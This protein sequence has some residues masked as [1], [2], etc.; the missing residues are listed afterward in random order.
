MESSEIIRAEIM[1]I[2]NENGRTNG[3][4]L[5]KRAI[6]KVGNEKTVYAEISAMVESGRIEKRVYSKSHIEY[7]IINYDKLASEQLEEIYNNVDMLFITIQNFET[8]ENG[9]FYD[10]LR[11]VIH[12]IYA[13][14]DNN[15][16]MK[17]LSFYPTFSRDK[18]F[19]QVTRRIDD[20][21]YEIMEVV[22]SQ[23][24]QD[25]IDN[26]FDSLRSRPTSEININ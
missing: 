6:S 4:E 12:L 11:H 14:E 26:V 23:D 13:I 10:R 8:D 3:T 24:E 18:M 7:E 19:R 17:I 16:M 5:A 21:W 9:S 20:C 22:S 25:F 2:L 15:A 1:R